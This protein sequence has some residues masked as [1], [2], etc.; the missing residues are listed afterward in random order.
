[1]LFTRLLRPKGRREWRI[2]QGL[3]RE[4]GHVSPEELGGEAVRDLGI[5]LS[6]CICELDTWV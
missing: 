3:E 6:K 5:F 2:L 4:G 1:M